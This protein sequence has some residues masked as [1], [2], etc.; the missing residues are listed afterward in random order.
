M[1]G[2]IKS[3]VVKKASTMNTAGEYWGGPQ[4]E[5]E[6]LWSPEN[7]F[8]TTAT[9]SRTPL[10]R[11]LQGEKLRQ[12]KKV[13]LGGRERAFQAD[14][15]TRGL[16]MAGLRKKKTDLATEEGRRSSSCL[17]DFLS[18]RGEGLAQRE[19]RRGKEKEEKRNEVK[20]RSIISEFRGI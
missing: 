15:L 13:S 4:L 9:A 14:L 18:R 10:Q 6:S 2:G 5:E 1:G 20:G 19:A 7:S 16:R 11:I 8:W 17:E 3:W 12:G